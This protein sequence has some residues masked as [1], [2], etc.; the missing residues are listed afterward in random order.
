MYLEIFRF[1]KI[2]FDATQQAN[3]REC[4]SSFAVPHLS[5]FP[6]QGVAPTHSRLSPLPRVELLCSHRGDRLPALFFSIKKRSPKLF[7]AGWSETGVCLDTWQVEGRW[8]PVSAVCDGCNGLGLDRC[9]T[10][11]QEKTDGLNICVINGR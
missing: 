11:T 10:S 1:T 8:K 5:L 4:L 6:Y 7:L 2:V 3:T 9:I